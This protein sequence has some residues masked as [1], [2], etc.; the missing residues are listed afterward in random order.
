MR[1]EPYYDNIINTSMSI[2][3]NI[4]HISQAVNLLTDQ[5]NILNE[6]VIQ[7]HLSTGRLVVLP[8]INSTNQYLINRIS[9]LQPGDA[10]VAE[11]QLHGRGRRGRKWISQFR[12]N[13][14]YSIY[15]YFKQQGPSVLIGLSLMVG[16]IV[17][18]I[19]QNFGVT[20]VLVKWPNDLYLNNRKLAGILV[21]M[22]G[23]SIVIG[24][25]I[26]LA[27][28]TIA[29]EWISLHEIGNYIIRNALVAE[30]TNALCKALL[31][32]E[33]EGFFPFMLRWRT[34]DYLYNKKV[35]ILLNEYQKV[36]GI[37]RGINT[38]GAFLLEQKGKIYSY[39]NGE[40]GWYS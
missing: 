13:I 22:I 15:W 38:Q 20:N 30:L 12:N 16:I 3:L 32:F 4:F 40:I 26:N 18:D 5:S 2:P 27:M 25:G 6:Q 11:Y 31:L 24:I 9:H 7:A 33:Q 39:I 23:Q 35:N 28:P 21:E 17:A 37:A 14:Y 29:K 36:T 1:L 34:L 8:V 10:C 19:L